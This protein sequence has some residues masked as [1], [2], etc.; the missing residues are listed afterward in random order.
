MLSS[1]VEEILG[2]N[3]KNKEKKAPSLPKQQCMNNLNTVYT[4]RVN[5]WFPFDTQ[6][7][8]IGCSLSLLDSDKSLKQY[9]KLQKTSRGG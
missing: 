9:Q 4:Y 5:I 8:I 6:R 1:S 3:Y 7:I 2:E